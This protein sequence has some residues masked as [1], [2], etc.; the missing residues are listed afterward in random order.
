MLA[1]WRRREPARDDDRGVRERARFAGAE[2]EPGDEQQVVVRHRAGQRRERRPPQHHARQHAARTD[3]IAE[4]AGGNLEQAV[5]QREHRRHPSPADGIDAEVLL[6]ARPRHGNADAV[7]V[8][9]GEQQDEKPRDA[10][11]VFH[12]WCGAGLVSHRNVRRL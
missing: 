3:A 7:D 1:R 12:G 6:H 4:R 11:A 8:G 2:A 9:D 10:G 5:G